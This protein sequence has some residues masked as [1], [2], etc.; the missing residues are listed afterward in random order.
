MRPRKWQIKDWKLVVDAWY[1]GVLVN[2]GKSPYGPQ[3][4]RTWIRNDDSDAPV[5]VRYIIAGCMV[6]EGVSARTAR[7]I[8]TNYIVLMNLPTRL[9]PQLWDEKSAGRFEKQ[10]HIKFRR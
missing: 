5:E 7:R 1:A 3:H 10:F 8:V 2:S 4:W 6:L 9:V